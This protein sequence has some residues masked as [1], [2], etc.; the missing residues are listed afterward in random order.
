MLSIFDLNISELKGELSF[1]FA[2]DVSEPTTG[3]CILRYQVEPIADVRNLSYQR[4]YR[5]TATVRVVIPTATNVFATDPTIYANYPVIL[6]VSSQ[7]KSGYSNFELVDYE[8][9]TVNTQVQSSQQMTS[10]TGASYSAEQ[11]SGSSTSQTNSYSVNASGGTMGGAPMASAGG[12]FSHSTTHEHWKSKSSGSQT[13]NYSTTGASAAMS[14]KDWG[15]YSWVDKTSK[16]PNWILAQ[17][18]PWDATS[19]RSTIPGTDPTKY[20]SDIVLPQAISYRLFCKVESYNFALPPSELSNFGLDFTLTSVWLVPLGSGAADQAIQFT[21]GFNLARATH[22]TDGDDSAYLDY[23]QKALSVAGPSLDLTQLGLD[24]V[25]P[26]ADNGAVIGFL[27]SKFIIAPG[28]TGSAKILSN[29]NNLQVQATGFAALSSNNSLMQA[30]V[31]AGGTASMTVSFKIIDPDSPFS[32][33]LKHWVSD[34]ACTLTIVFNGQ[35]DS[36]ITILVDDREGAGGN[37]N[38][39]SIVL[40][41]NDFSSINYHDYLVL[42]LN[43]IAISIATAD[44]TASTYVIRAL[45]LE[46]G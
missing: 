31:S 37:D 26:T 40:R 17:E 20:G 15:I 32:L 27:L 25:D 3:A 34:G 39:S 42:G 30:S 43:T 44:A 35:I 38:V 9:R 23:A 41:N 46:F 10:E 6:A 36:P 24:P 11:S 21:H 5:I 13:V 33:A 16:S 8:P 7:P 12:D 28:G 45:A 22:T 4:S 14:I 19:F 2:A 1:G 29:A 18:Y